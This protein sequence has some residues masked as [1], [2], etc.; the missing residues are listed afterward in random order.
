[1]LLHYYKHKLVRFTGVPLMISGVWRLT[2]KNKQR[3]KTNQCAPGWARISG[4]KK[5]RKHA[6]FLCR[7][8]KSM[9][10]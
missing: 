8:I 6:A 7:D 9:I 10:Y 1:M 3:S 5:R 2:L 4:H